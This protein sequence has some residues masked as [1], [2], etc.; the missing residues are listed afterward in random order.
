[1]KAPSTSFNDLFSW[2][3]LLSTVGSFAGTLTQHCCLKLN[4]AGGEQAPMLKYIL[5]KYSFRAG[6]LKHVR[7]FLKARDP[8]ISLTLSSFH[9]EIL[10]A[11]PGSVCL[12]EN[13]RKRH[14]WCVANVMVEEY[15]RHLDRFYLE[16]RCRLYASCAWFFWGIYK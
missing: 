13:S 6:E 3:K 15:E 9:T 16:S 2:C 5:L 8:I 11:T 4:S 7:V 1:M 14:I 10:H 12:K